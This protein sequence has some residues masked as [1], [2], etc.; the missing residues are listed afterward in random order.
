[1]LVEPEGV[2]DDEQLAGWLERATKFVKKL[3][4]K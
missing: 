1:M 2:E 4:K 3:P